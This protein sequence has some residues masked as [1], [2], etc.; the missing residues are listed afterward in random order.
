MLIKIKNKTLRCY[1]IKE[2]YDVRKTDINN[3]RR[4]EQKRMFKHLM[5]SV[6][7]KNH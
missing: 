2:L 3:R 7:F 5:E 1:R 6:V 4:I